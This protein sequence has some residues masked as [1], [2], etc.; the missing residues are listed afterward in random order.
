MERADGNSY[1]LPVTAIC[2]GIPAPIKQP[3]VERFVRAG[4]LALAVPFKLPVSLIANYKE[5]TMRLALILSL[6][7]A[8]LLAACSSVRRAGRPTATSKLLTG[9]WSM[10]KRRLPRL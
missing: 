9:G 5:N 4:D 6:I 1:H 3:R 7:A 2:H 10:P 8:S